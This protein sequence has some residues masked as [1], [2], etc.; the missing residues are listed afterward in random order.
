MGFL[1]GDWKES[2]AGAFDIMDFLK[3]LVDLADAEAGLVQARY[4]TKLALAGLEVIL[5]RRLFPSESPQ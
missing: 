4:A 1:V 5:G 3:G 2:L